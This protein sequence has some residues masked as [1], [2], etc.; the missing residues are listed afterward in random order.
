MSSTTGL[1]YQQLPSSVV[2]PSIHARCPRC[3]RCFCRLD[4][5]LQVSASCRNVSATPE[6]SAAPPSLSLPAM[7][8]FSCTVNLNSIVSTE[9]V[10]TCFEFH[11]NHNYSNASSSPM[12][13]SVSPALLH[14]L[15]L[16]SP[17]FPQNDIT[18]PSAF[19]HKEPLRLP[20]SPEEWKEADRLLSSV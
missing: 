10:S 2:M 1:L 4:T 17:D 5:H 7:N 6:C 12:D 11:R 9:P 3:D 18:S 14:N 15:P 20:S 8:T 16:I 13:I 19:N